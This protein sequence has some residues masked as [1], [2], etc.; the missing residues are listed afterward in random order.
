MSQTALTT[1]SSLSAETKT[2]LGLL[3]DTIG[4]ME[5][6]ALTLDEI[7]RCNAHQNPFENPARAYSRQIEGQLKYYQDRWNLSYGDNEFGAIYV[8]R[9]QGYCKTLLIVPAHFAGPEDIFGKWKSEAKF[10]VWK[11]DDAKSLNY[12]IP[13]DRRRLGHYA[14]LHSGRQEADIGL[15]NYSWDANFRDRIEMMRV[16]E[17]LLWEDQYFTEHKEHIDDKTTVTLTGSR[18][19]DGYAVRV[20]WDP[21]SRLFYVNRCRTQLADPNL[22]SRAVSL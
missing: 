1:G 18:D 19:V 5:R 12:L 4:Q 16:T 9:P 2:A 10:G 8:P 14:L 20:R 15:Q 11:W 6:E 21:D 17:T 13:N 7:S 22:C 3:K